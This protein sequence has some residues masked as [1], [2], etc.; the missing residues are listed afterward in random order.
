[1]TTIQGTNGDDAIN[2]T[3]GDDCII[4]G[5]GNDTVKFTTFGKFLND[6]FTAG[7]F[8]IFP[9]KLQAN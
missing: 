8:H 7:D 9:L 5:A 3:G 4:A 6:Y 2:G 1:M